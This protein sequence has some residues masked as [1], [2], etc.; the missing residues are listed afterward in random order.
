MSILKLKKYSNYIA[1]ISFIGVLGIN[2]INTNFEKI[3]NK[4][5]KVIIKS[6][7]NEYKTEIEKNNDKNKISVPL[8]TSESDI[9]TLPVPNPNSTI[10]TSPLS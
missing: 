5:A 10:I 9:K 2:L 1:I 8:Q 4:S 7:K 3:E 6:N